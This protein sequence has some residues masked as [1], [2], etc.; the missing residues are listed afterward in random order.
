MW[1]PCW[2]V[3]S[4]N[5]A[6][7]TLHTVHKFMWSQPCV[8]Y[9]YHRQQFHCLPHVILCS[10]YLTLA[11]FIYAL[12]LV[13][14]QSVKCVHAWRM[15][16]YLLYRHT[17]VVNQWTVT[18]MREPFP[19]TTA[20]DIPWQRGWLSGLFIQKSL[21]FFGNNKTNTGNVSKG[22]YTSPR[23]NICLCLCC[24]FRR[25]TSY[26]WSL[27]PAVSVRKIK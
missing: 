11:L 20:W 7:M 10:L 23:V 4:G 9:Q 15:V 19:P 5:L 26:C 18:S 27:Q 12:A 3:M 24:F 2:R 17:W 1:C 8:N 25:D 14:T 6:I 16:D 22:L 13:W 21:C